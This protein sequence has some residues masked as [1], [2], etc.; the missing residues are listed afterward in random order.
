[1]S[2]DASL[3]YPLAGSAQSLRSYVTPISLTAGVASLLIGFTCFFLGAAGEG[4]PTTMRR[5]YLRFYTDH[6]FGLESISA[7]VST[8]GMAT[9]WAP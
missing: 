8:I 4:H 5:I 7:T 9:F 6:G 1:M 3:F 2:A